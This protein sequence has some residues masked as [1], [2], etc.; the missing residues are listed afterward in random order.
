MAQIPEPQGRAPQMLEAAV[1][2]LCRPVARPGPVEVGEHISSPAFQRSPQRGQL[3]QCC[4]HSC[5]KTRDDT[6]Q[7]VSAARAVGVAVRGHDPLVDPPCDIDLGVF[8]GSEH[9]SSLLVCFLVSRFAP[10]SRTR[11]MP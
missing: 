10:V 7:S 5:R 11:R 3:L 9:T 2:R 8:L 4:R 6:L 1:D